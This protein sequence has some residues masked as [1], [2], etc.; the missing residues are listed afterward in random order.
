MANLEQALSWASRRLRIFPIPFGE[1]RPDTSFLELATSDPEQIKLLWRDPITGSKEF[2]I[3]VLCGD[4][5]VIV[6]IDTKFDKKFRRS[7]VSNYEAAGGHWNTL[8]VKTASGGYQAYYKL[9]EG[10]EYGNATNIVP[11]VD[12]RC[13]NGYGIAPGSFSIKSGG[14]YELWIDEDIAPVPPPILHLLKPMASKKDRLNGHADPIKAIPLYTDWLKRVAPAIEGQG[15]DN[16]TYNVACMGVIDYGLSV[17][18]VTNL[19]LEHFNPR[20]QP[21]WELDEL[22]QKAENADTYGVGRLGSR[23]PDAILDGVVYTVPAEPP[24][25]T[26]VIAARVDDSD[27]LL[28]ADQIP[29]TRWLLH[30]MLT[31]SVVTMYAGPGGVGKS[32]WLVAMACHAAIG[33]IDFGPYHFYKPFT[34][35]LY[36]PE[37]DKSYVSGRA[38]VICRHYSLDYEQAKKRFKV[39]DQHNEQIVLIEMVSRKLVIPDRTVRFLSDFSNKYP[40]CKLMVFDP[41]RKMMRGV[42]ENNNS[43]MTDAMNLLNAIAYSLDKSILVTHHTPKNYVQRK[44]FDMSNPDAASGAGAIVTSAR[45]VVNMFPQGAADIEKQGK[46]DELF[47]VGVVKNNHGPLGKASW[48]ERRILVAPNGEQYPCPVTTDVKDAMAKIHRDYIATMGDYMLSHEINALSVNQAAAV[49]HDVY[50]EYRSIRSLADAL[51]IIFHRGDV[52][53]EYVDLH[54]VRYTMALDMHDKTNVFTLI[55]MPGQ[56]PAPAMVLPPAPTGDDNE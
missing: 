9:P 40:D 54:G 36:S 11:G 30:P 14:E 12:V 43:M 4:G 8:V 34:T 2:N 39:F 18:T 20:C 37:D 28:P 50:P 48:W 49:I 15:G 31:Q 16:H 22:I 38:F 56:A 32:S 41:L 46:R 17:P 23:D 26:T 33:N 44:D 55:P 10:Q 42:D 7:A 13:H 3:G 51:R 45:I 52:A 27:E 5:L 47:S 25:A 53:H 6:D 19:M 29:V 24:K 21:P 35:M 1:K